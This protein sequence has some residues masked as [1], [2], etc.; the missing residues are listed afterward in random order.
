M[1]VGG[2]EVRASGS[3]GLVVRAC[4]SSGSGGMGVIN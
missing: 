4:G 1:V 2:L 3:R